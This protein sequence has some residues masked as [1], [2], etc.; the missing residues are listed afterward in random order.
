MKN[1]QLNEKVRINLNEDS[2]TFDILYQNVN[3][4]NEIEDLI[5]YNLKNQY[6]YRNS[7]NLWSSVYQLGN[8]IARYILNE[9]GTSIEL[10]TYFK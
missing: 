7:I 8:E 5:F 2:Y 10:H 4:K 6:N 9:N 3:S 1:L